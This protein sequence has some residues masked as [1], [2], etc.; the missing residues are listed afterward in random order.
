MAWNIGDILI[1][2]NP[3][4]NTWQR[5]F[6]CEVLSDV[7]NDGIIYLGV[8]RIFIPQAPRTDSGSPYWLAY[9]QELS[10][11]PHPN[12]LA[13][14]NEKIFKPKELVTITEPI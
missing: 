2:S 14:W 11:P 5:G 9:P 1:I 13:E 7:I 10:L 6:E 4:N 3:I 8:H 12:E